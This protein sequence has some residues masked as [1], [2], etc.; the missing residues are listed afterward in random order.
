MF[1]WCTLHATSSM[2]KSQVS[3]IQPKRGPPAHFSGTQ[4]CF[5]L[6]RVPKQFFSELLT[7]SHLPN[8]GEVYRGKKMEKMNHAFEKVKM[9]VG[10]EVDEEQNASAPPDDG[11]FSFM[12]DFNRSCTLSTKQVRLA[13]EKTLQKS[14]HDFTTFSFFCSAVIEE[15]TVAQFHCSCLFESARVQRFAVAFFF[16]GILGLSSETR[17][18]QDFKFICIFSFK[19]RISY[20]QICCGL[21]ERISKHVLSF[22]LRGHVN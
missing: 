13:A 2:E 20:S 8:G 19:Q 3:L 10:M 16:I 21:G 11:P 5:L 22:L 17:C 15:F 14:N 7:L 9:L 1:R 6:T 12:D 4:G 18:F